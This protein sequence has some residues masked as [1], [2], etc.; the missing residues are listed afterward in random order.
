M[1]KDEIP[2]APISG[3]I[4]GEIAYWLMIIG[5]VIAVVGS[6]IYMAS[7]GYL[8][9]ATLLNCLWRGD[10]CR[11]IW[12]EC[13]GLT[14]IPRGHWYLGALPCGD[15]IAMLGI[16]ISAMAAV[17]G[18]WGAFVGT[19]R[20]REGIYIIFALVISVILTLSALGIIH[21]EM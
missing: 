10:D 4:Y 11:T 7:D 1:E 14:E 3:I 6:G 18:M 12:K 8:D 13:A 15:A 20:R 17:V 16:A 5:L 9:K 19:L 21:L 2:K